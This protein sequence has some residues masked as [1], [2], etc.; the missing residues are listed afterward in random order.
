MLQV[1][2]NT[3]VWCYR[4]TSL[5]LAV[6]LAVLWGVY[7]ACVAFCTAWCCVPCIK[8]EEI[9][10][11]CVKNV[12]RLTI[13]TFVAPCFDAIGRCFSNIGVRVNKEWL[14][15]SKTGGI[16]FN[17][18]VQVLPLQASTP[19]PSRPVSNHSDISDNSLESWHQRYLE[20][21]LKIINMILLSPQLSKHQW[22]KGS[23]SHSLNLNGSHFHKQPN[24]YTKTLSSSQSKTYVL[25]TRF[26]AFI[27]VYKLV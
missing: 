22:M 8:S 25:P 14:A 20:N 21:S 2:T 4:I 10:L 7:F 16:R 26:H 11:R 12:W 6:P 1:F 13:D 3:K 5:I 9:E 27:Y 15:G 17:E 19:R 18:N 23:T 24:I